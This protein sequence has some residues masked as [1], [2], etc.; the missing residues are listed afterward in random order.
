MTRR[1]RLLSGALLLLLPA[2]AGAQQGATITGTVRS[3]SQVSIPGAFVSLPELNLSTITNA[4]GVYRIVVPAEKA[5]GQTT[6]RVSSIGYR[7]VEE[8]V[9]LTPGVVQHDVVM[10]DEAVALEQLLVTGT[11]IGSQQRKAQ[12][13]VIAS[14][15]TAD[16]T[17]NAPVTSVTEILQSRVPGVSVTASSGSSGTTQ[18]IRIRGPASL[19]LSN[20]P[21]V[22]IDGVLTDS[23]SRQPFFTGGQASSRLFD[24]DPED[25]ESI[26]IV[27]GPAAATLY[28]ADASAGVI[29]IITKKGRPGSG[30]FSQNISLEYNSIDQNW[31]PPSNF[32]RCTAALVAPT[33]TNPLCRGQAVGTLVQDNPLVREG[34]F[35]TGNAKKLGWSGRGGGEQYGYYASFNYDKED[36]TLPNNGLD[37][38]SG[39]INFNWSPDPKLTMNAGFGLIRTVNTLPDNDNN[40]YGFLGGA[41]LGSPLTRVDDDLASQVGRNN[42]WYAPNRNVKAISSISNQITSVR[43]TPTFTLNYT[44]VHWF[45]NRLTVGA[46]LSRGEAAKLYPKNANGWYSAENNT[47]NITEDR[48]HYDIYTI[49]Y[50][51]NVR[52][53][54]G[55]GE[56]WTSDLSFGAQLNDTR[57]DVLGGS[58]LGLVTNAAHV[59]SA[60]SSRSAYQS[61]SQQRSI[62]LLAQEQIG[63]K[64]RLFVQV[65]FR[66]DQNSAFGS[67]VDPFFLPKIG[68]SYVLSDEP[69]F[70]DRFGFVSTLRLRGSYGTSG[71]SPT[72]GASLETYDPAPYAIGAATGAG[73]VP[74]NPGNPNLKP[75]RGEEFEGGLDAGLFNDRVGFEVTYF[76]KLSKD[77]LL[78]KPLPPSLG[79]VDQSGGTAQNPY[80]NIGRVINEGIEA[81]FHA[82][83]ISSRNVGWDFRIGVNTLHNEILDMGDVPAFGTLYRFREGDQAGAFHSLKIR[84]IDVANEK[85]IVSDTIEHVGNLWPTFEGNAG[86]NLTLFQKIRFYAQF[87]W[88]TGFSVYNNTD[89][90]RERQFSNGERR[91][92]LREVDYSTLTD[93]QKIERLRRFGSSLP[94]VPTFVRENGT[95]A[96]VND[97]TEAYIQPGDFLRFRELSMTLNLPASLAQRAGAQSASLTLGARNLALWT[98]YEGADPEVVSDATA[99]F[100]REDFLTV[101]QTRQF[102]ARLNFQF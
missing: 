12:P 65:G 78:R 57:T 72:P 99:N 31:D 87:D 21:L 29:Q 86:T 100:S 74:L 48:N 75:E 63:F 47:G 43:A 1:L 30:R 18:Q 25:I 53:T 51:G 9:T 20:Q 101:P 23:R 32:G 70:R 33:S 13:A 26:E 79:Y 98:K 89:Q 22:Y 36:G 90:F 83:P 34:A 76:H 68:F 88:K 27:K 69:A 4:S 97:V 102:I 44:P 58:G 59:I 56:T 71:R 45:T 35:R 6:L 92:T 84:S 40:I 39:R 7:P 94:G 19:S 85:V 77:L 14:I 67:K 2:T 42:G 61:F 38:R 64:N 24:I 41:L 28:G 46:D 55:E 3:R 73:V 82:T 5:T 54:F 52:T 81:A 37:R 93:A 62:G 91:Q 8:S 10:A 49:D 96:T 66:V 15:N 60:A 95:G 50:Q 11:A 80:V 16:L 17:R